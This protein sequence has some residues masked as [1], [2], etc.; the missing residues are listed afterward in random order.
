[1]YEVYLER[2]AECDLKRLPLAIFS[3]I[4]PYIQSLAEN[5]RT[6]NCIKIWFKKV[7]HIFYEIDEKQRS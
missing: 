5:P 4:I 1:M 3:Q 7:Y 6:S 2:S